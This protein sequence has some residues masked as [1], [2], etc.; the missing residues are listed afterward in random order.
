[1]PYSVNAHLSSAS[2]CPH[3]KILLFHFSVI[4]LRITIS[5]NSFSISSANAIHIVLT[6]DLSL[7]SHK[8]HEIG[9]HSGPIKSESSGDRTVFKLAMIPSVSHV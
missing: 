9:L 1:M 4:A 5:M 7:E 3:G 2:L 6:L 8:S